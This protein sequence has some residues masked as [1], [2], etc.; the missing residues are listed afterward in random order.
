MAWF[1]VDDGFYTSHKVLQISR[2]KRNEAIGAW[3]LIGT[4]SAHKM[5]DGFVP[6]YV[7]DEYNVSTELL[8]ILVS[9]N[10]WILVDGGIRFHDW[11][12]YQPTRDELMN[13]R[14]EI[15]KKR[16]EAGSK[17]AAKR[18]QNG[19]TIANAWQND[20]KRIANDSPE[21]EP[22]PE[23]DSVRAKR[24]TQM[25][26]NWKPDADLLQWAEEKAKDVDV[27]YQT[28][29]FVNYWLSVGRP[30]K[31]WRATWRNWM[32]RNQK[33]APIR[34]KSPIVRPEDEWRYLR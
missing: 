21:P 26:E 19:K 20:S 14:G 16:S 9:V 30:M 4:W 10:L 15:S 2:N 25:T 22:E 5:T 32:I 11:E 31:D 29:R 33:D 34:E 27:D 12:H 8:D 1:K 13:R 6:N 23:P 24:A 28:E 7:L 17:G 3:L 18:W